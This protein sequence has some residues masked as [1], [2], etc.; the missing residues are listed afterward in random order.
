MRIEI[1]S[2]GLHSLLNAQNGGADCAELCDALEVG[3]LTPSMGMLETVKKYA[4]IPVRVLIRPRPGN[5]IY[6]K[7]DLEVMLRDTETARRLGYEGV[8]VGA[9]N[10]D[11]LL[12]IEKIKAMLDAGKGMK[13]TFHRA[14]DACK[15]IFGAMEQLIEMGF[16]KVLTSG[17]KHTALEGMDTIA[18]MQKRFGNRINIMPGGG[19]NASNIQAI[20]A[21]T[22]VTNCHAS[23]S[24]NVST[25]NEV[26]YPEQV[27]ATG[28]SMIWKETSLQKVIEF[29]KVARRTFL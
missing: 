7:T 4:T 10:D 23:L 25:Y 21:R 17:G 26:L 27:D 29:V 28:V 15:D 16:D 12:D 6:D 1:C 3:G 22:K 11:G 5:Y 18:E 14:I 24:Q 19:I 13:F 9:L 20:M 2:N 8:V